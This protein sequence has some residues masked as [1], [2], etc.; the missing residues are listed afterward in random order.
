MFK[1]E[2]ASHSGCLELK[3][4]HMAIALD[5]VTLRCFGKIFI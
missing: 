1:V 2:R 4:S 5:L 3:V